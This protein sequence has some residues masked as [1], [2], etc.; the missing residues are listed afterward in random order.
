MRVNQL[1]QVVLIAFML[2]SCAA[3]PEVPAKPPGPWQDRTNLCQPVIP[4]VQG[5][6]E[7]LV[8]LRVRPYSMESYDK[9]IVDLRSQRDLTLWFSSKAQWVLEKNY[10]HQIEF[11]PSETAGTWTATLTVKSKKVSTDLRVSQGSAI[12]ETPYL[13]AVEGPISDLI[14]LVIEHGKELSFLLISDE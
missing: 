10:D 11:S 7:D 8:L 12:Q 9:L 14:T 1:L 4:S 13:F 3:A 2:T 5:G 6:S